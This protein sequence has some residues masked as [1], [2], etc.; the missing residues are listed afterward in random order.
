MRA[1]RGLF[2]LVL[3]TSLGTTLG[4]EF[5]SLA[6]SKDGRQTMNGSVLPLDEDR[7]FYLRNEDGLVEVIMA[8]DVSIGLLFRERGIFQ[9]L[10][11]R[12]VVINEKTYPLP[13]N[14]SVR[15]RFRDWKTAQRA[16]ETGNLTGGR[17]VAES[18]PEHLPTERELWLSGPLLRLEPGHITPKKITRVAER[19]FEVSTSGHNYSEQVLGLFGPGDVT[20][21]DHQA[22]VYGTMKGKVFHAD[23]V[24]LRPV[25]DPVSKDDLALPRCLFIGD[26]ISLNYTEGL[27]A[28][29]KGKVNVH[30]PPTNC[31]PSEKCA[32][33]AQIWLGHFEEEGRGWDVISFN[34]GHWDAGN[35]KAEYQANLERLIAQLKMTG[36][37]LIW[38]TTCPVPHGYEKVGSLKK[39]G[40]AP[41][42]QSGVMEKFLN[43]WALEVMKRHPGIT[44]CDQWRFVKEGGEGLYR[45]WWAGKNVHFKGEAADALGKLLAL[46]ILERLRE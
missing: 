4:Q 31:G 25:I 5:R 9:M 33:R 39:D 11:E 35:S 23:E 16:V 40:S 3:L 42:R 27:Q 45:D 34:C 14:L 32:S 41:G 29:L 12:K 36:A 17:V 24:L 46:Q 7:R 30:H 18:L 37:K 6:P 13:E 21:H 2:G 44:I 10:Q 19:E 22:S 28:A 26:S 43:P 1:R 15:V 38:V 20:P 8:E